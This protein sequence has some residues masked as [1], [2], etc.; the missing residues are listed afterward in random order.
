MKY[1]HKD[2]IV[3]AG[4]ISDRLAHIDTYTNLPYIRTKNNNKSC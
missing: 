2:K 3:Y 4:K 1:V